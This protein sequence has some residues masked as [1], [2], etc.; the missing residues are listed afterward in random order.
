MDYSSTSNKIFPENSNYNEE[1][2]DEDLLLI[3]NNSY[4]KNNGHNP[5]R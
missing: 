1:N 3:E 2:N 5:D 4:K